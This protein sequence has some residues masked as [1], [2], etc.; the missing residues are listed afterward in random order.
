MRI[1]CYINFIQQDR[2]RKL[3]ERAG[4]KEEEIIVIMDSVLDWRDPTRS[5]ISLALRTIIMS[6]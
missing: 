4:V 1:H 5:I 6:H 2:L 3:L